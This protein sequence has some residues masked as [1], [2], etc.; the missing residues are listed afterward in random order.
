MKLT[1]TVEYDEP[2]D[3]LKDAATVVDSIR[4]HIAHRAKPSD[5]DSDGGSYRYSYSG[6][7]ALGD[8]SCTGGD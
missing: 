8:W 5:S 3:C 1:V 7:V 6:F 2:D 4:G